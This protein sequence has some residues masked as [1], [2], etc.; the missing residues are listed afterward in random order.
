MRRLVPWALLSLVA[1]GAAAGAALGI[2]RGTP[3]ET[4][5]Q[6]VA[7]VLAATQRAGTARF[8]YT[9][10]TSSPHVDLRDSLSGSG[11]VNFTAGDAQVSEVDHDISF[12]S[13]DNQPAHPVPTTSRTKTIVIGQTVYQA[14]PIPGFRFT[15]QYHALPFHN[16]PKAQR[17]LSLALNA[18]VALDSLRGSNAVA[19]VRAVGRATIDGTPVTQYR[20]SFAP[21]R[22]CDPHQPPMVLTERPS[23][24]WVDDAGRLLQ[25]RSTSYLSGRLPGGERLPSGS[26]AFPLGPATSVDTLTFSAFGVPVHVVAPAGSA[27]AP[28]GGSSVAMLV[29]RT[30]SC[31]RP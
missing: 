2:M 17:G 29:A 1:V 14:N 11:A 31:R 13:T 27:L 5:S 24:L 30:P 8:T 20:V 28:S 10:V 22:V 23:A 4:A 19:S 9:H 26:G 6:W 12:D 16:L 7:A 18:G 15:A 21:V 25:V 3:P